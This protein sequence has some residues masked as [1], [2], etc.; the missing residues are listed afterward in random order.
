[1]HEGLGERFSV[2]GRAVG[3]SSKEGTSGAAS[4]KRLSNTCKGLLVLLNR[5]YFHLRVLESGLFMLMSS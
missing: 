5:S 3:R 4:V 2:L 1:V